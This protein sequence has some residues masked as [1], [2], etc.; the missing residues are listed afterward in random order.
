VRD[1]LLAGGVADNVDTKFVWAHIKDKLDRCVFLLSSDRIEIA[2]ACLPTDTTAAF[3]K[4]VRRVYLT[5][6]LPSAVE[7]YRTF[8]S[9]P[10]RVRPEGRSG[11]AQRVFLEAH[12]ATDAKQRE[13]AKVL[14]NDRKA[15]ILT[16]SGSQAR[17]W[18][19][20]AAVF[21]KKDDH[22]TVESFATAGPP[23]KLV[24]AGRYDGVDLPGDA[25]RILVLDGLPLGEALLPRYVGE[26][27][28]I[29]TVRASTTAVRIVQAVGRIFRSNTDH[30]AV[31][32]IG[33]RLHRWLDS[34]FNRSFLPPLL[35]RQLE[36][37]AAIDKKIAAG[38]LSITDVMDA[39]LNGDREWDDFYG[40]NIGQ[41]ASRPPAQPPVWLTDAVQREHAAHRKMWQDNFAEAATEYS[42]LA[43]LTGPNDA[44]LAAWYRHFEGYCYERSGK[45][46]LAISAYVVAANRRSSLGRPAIKPN[47]RA[48]PRVSG[49]GSE[50]AERILK[51]VKSDG[52]KALARVKAIPAQLTY[53]TTAN[54]FEQAV[55]DVGSYIGLDSSRPDNDTGAGPDVLWLSGDTIGH[56]FEAK[57]EKRSDT[58]YTKAEIG[59]AH[60]HKQWLRDKHPK[61]AIG[62]SLIGRFLDVSPHASPDDELTVLEA[63]PFQELANKLVKLYEELTTLAADAD[64]VES[65]VQHLG[66]KFPVCLEA[67]PQRMA[68]D[69]QIDARE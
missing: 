10:E 22:A 69:L 39:V 18:S 31:L 57:T 36:L 66:L 62:L 7:F 42:D 34:P 65:W 16:G 46:D 38:E 30:G 40:E 33:N 8:G 28:R 35:Q 4:Q 56:A 24:M 17:G 44:D 43:A 19:D 55:K 60:N 32:L 64:I 3:G 27:L 63:P 6:T 52:G 61:R 68:T 23:A 47:E 1:R 25:C 29:D 14:L 11:E 9:L 13:A 26:S 21:T 53:S 50:Q 58:E 51:I 54:Q 5:A 45:H 48:I 2:P 41:F 37:A 67:M 59:Q 49:I 15:F 12:G 20:C